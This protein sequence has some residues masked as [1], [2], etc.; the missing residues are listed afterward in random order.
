MN[1]KVLQEIANKYSTPSYVF[2]EQALQR[3][4]ELVSDILGDQIKLCYSMKANPFLVPTMLQFV[5]KIEVCSPGELAICEEYNVD[6]SRIIYSGVNKGIED[7]RQAMKDDVGVY[8][9]ESV[10]Q[11][12]LIEQAAAELSEKKDVL[13]RLNANSQFGM[14]REVVFDL[15]KNRHKYPH[16]RIKGIHYFVGTQRKKTNSHLAELQMLRE[17]F[18]EIEEKCNFSIDELEY[19]PGL[20]VPYF[21]NDSFEDTLMPLREIRDLLCDVSTE[22]KLTVEMGRFFVAECG[23]Y[24]SEIVD[25]KKGDDGLKYAILDGGMN[26]LSYIGQTMGMRTPRIRHIRKGELNDVNGMEEWCLCGS[27]CSVNDVIARKASF[28]G[29]KIGDVLVFGNTGAYSVT[30]GIYLFLSRKLPQIMLYSKEGR[31]EV[32]REHIESYRLNLPR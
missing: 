25:T 26:H 32:L 15:V 28:E 10:R 12:E 27:I 4:M 30:E 8:T 11:F 19:G 21:E 7:I 17:F 1:A 13:L 22:V 31:I 2:D 6:G 5:N 20:P 23:Y 18:L 29:L 24:F 3:R 9:A 16:I 14:S